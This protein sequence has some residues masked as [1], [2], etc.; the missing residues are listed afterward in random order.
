MGRWGKGIYDSDQ[1]LDYHIT[2]TNLLDRELAYWMIPENVYPG[3]FWLMQV[4]SVIE[5][6]LIFEYQ[7]MGS[8]NAY[9]AAV[10]RIKQ[11]REVFF[12]V[13]DEDWRDDREFYPYGA[14]E[15]RRQQRP[16]VVALFDSLESLAWMWDEIETNLR[17]DAKVLP[18]PPEYSLPY[19]SLIRW[20]SQDGRKGVRVDRFTQTLLTHLLKDILYYLSHEE[21]ENATIFSIE[22]VWVAVDTLGFLC[23]IYEQS[24]GVTEQMVRAWRETTD[25]I[26]KESLDDYWVETNPL[27]GNVMRVFDRLEAVARKYPLSLW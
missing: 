21:R 6:M 11:W 13:W 23:E 16:G 15:Y 17:T 2:I 26:N 3:G 14:P 24:P 9:I 27:Y 25:Q 10:A 22:E 4:V 20:A 8:S 1:A 7:H 12:N 18:M 19:F 5:V